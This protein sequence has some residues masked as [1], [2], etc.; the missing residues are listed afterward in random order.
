MIRFDLIGE[1]FVVTIDNPDSNNGLDVESVMQFRS[2]VALASEHSQCRFL[3][4]KGIPRWFCIGGSGPFLEELLEANSA[5]RIEASANVQAL[6]VDVLQSPLMTVAIVDGLAAGAGA[7]LVLACDITFVT[8]NARFSLLYGKLGL[9]PDTGFLLLQERFG[10][11]ALKHY[12]ESRVLRANEIVE[13]GIGEIISSNETIE[14]L[15]VSLGRRFRHQRGA[16]ELAKRL[17]NERISFGLQSH[18]SSAAEFQAAV[19]DYDYARERIRLSS[20]AQR[21]SK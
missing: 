12:A 11:D 9:V 19:M 6:I 4:I 1:F 16:Y 10:W 20:A 3:V 21:S 17:R 13:L 5:D 2:A 7:D 8:Q 14:T 18:L 15:L